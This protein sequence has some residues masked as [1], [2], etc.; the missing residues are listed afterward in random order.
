MGYKESSAYKRVAREASK[1][2]NEDHVKN[3][4]KAPPAPS[5][6]PPSNGVNTQK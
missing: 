4:G 6:P 3:F 5:P 2:F 1:R